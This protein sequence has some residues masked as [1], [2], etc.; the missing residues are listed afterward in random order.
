MTEHEIVA[1]VERK[2]RRAL[3]SR[4]TVRAGDVV[5][6]ATSGG[7]DSVALLLL[8]HRFKEELA[9]E[10]A[11]LH[12]DHALRK[13]SGRDRE[14]VE[15]LADRLGLEFIWKREDVASLAKTRRLSVEEAARRA[16][17]AWFKELLD[18]GRVSRVATGHNMDD[19]AETVL[20]RIVRGTGPDGL[21]S[22]EPIGMDGKIIRPLL[23]VRKRDLER[24]VRARGYSFVIDET[25][26]SDSFVRN[27]IRRDLI[28][29]LEEINPRV[30]E[31]LARLASVAFDLKSWLRRKSDDL[32]SS[33][34]EAQEE[35]AILLNRQKLLALDPFERVCAVRRALERVVGDPFGYEYRDY[36]RI[37][38][39]IG[40]SD[41]FSWDA[42]RGVRIEMSS[43]LIRIGPPAEPPVQDVC[44]IPNVG[45][46]ECPGLGIRVSVRRR[47]ITSARE[48]MNY[49]GYS[50]LLDADRIDFPLYI[51]FPK[52]G[53]RFFPLGAP[54]EKK[55]AD[56]FVDAKIPRFVRKKVPLLVS[57]GEIAWVIGHRISH[58]FRITPKTKAALEITVDLQS[59][60]DE[61]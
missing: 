45:E 48:A 29:A 12:F 17:Y 9:V 35:G 2:F 44:E 5:G 34:I 25:N 4:C 46:Y 52:E 22:I 40:S 13:S 61:S 55:L 14:F 20:Y 58:I 28:P 8:F 42:G 50:A 41:S 59:S 10:L 11:V 57:G 37:V 31:S 7:P 33:C 49:S 6:V 26:L 39:L 32:L 15:K 53:D 19:Q 56:F 1:E 30:V 3:E 54:G 16:R 23:D 27:R 38:S 24:Y 51:R 18:A 47:P 60:A 21:S 43:G 36:T